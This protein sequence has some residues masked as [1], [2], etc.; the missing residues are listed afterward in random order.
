MSRLPFFYGWLMVPAV[1]LIS[2]CT[3]PG[4]TYGV[5]VF[6][7][8]LREALGLSNSELS[9]AYMAG[10]VLASLPLT[11]IGALMDRYGPLFI[12]FFFLRLLGQGSMGMLARNALAMWFH[13]RL[14]F[15]SGL[16]NL[17]MAAAVGGMP[18]LGFWL[19]E[20]YGWRGAYAVLGGAVWLLLPAY[21]NHGLWGAMMIYFVARG[22]TL[23]LRY[24]ALERAAG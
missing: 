19:I 6:N 20:S 17:G 24:P 12:A 1:M 15:A 5:A 7:P 9:G 21:G 13:K 14:G 22:V 23:F 18:A 10:T 16:A 3:S 4:Q 11:Y 8:Y 2:I